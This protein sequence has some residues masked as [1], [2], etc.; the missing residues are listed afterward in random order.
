[1][2]KNFGARALSYPMAVYLVTTYNPDG[3]ANTMNAAWGGVS[4]DHEFTLCLSADHKTVKNLQRTGAFTISI[5]DGRHV[6]EC[7]YVGLASGN[8]VANK[9]QQAGFTVSKSTL[10]NAPMINELS[11]CIECTVINYNPETCVLVGDIVNVSVDESA[12]TDGKVDI[13]KVLPLIYDP[14]N[15]TYHLVGAKVGNAFSD[16]KQLLGK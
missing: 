6:V 15:H 5:G 1:M 16:G 11:V 10:V 12:L 9:V 7:D 8:K 3:T 13:Q 4:N 2:R 14:F